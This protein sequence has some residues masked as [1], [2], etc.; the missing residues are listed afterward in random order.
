MQGVPIGMNAALAAHIR[1]LESMPRERIRT[2]E[3]PREEPKQGTRYKAGIPASMVDD[4]KD[5]KRAGLKY[6]EIRAQLG[7]GTKTMRI[8]SQMAY[9]PEQLEA[10]RKAG[11]DRRRQAVSA[12]MK[13]RHDD[14]AWH[15]H[16]MAKMREGSERKRLERKK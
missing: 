1:I 11:I 4:Y 16:A 3:R 15:A 2:H 7:I 10:D 5:L 14:Q 12:A 13:R 8:V 9:S 6:D